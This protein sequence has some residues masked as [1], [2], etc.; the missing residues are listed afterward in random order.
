HGP[1]E[2]VL[3]RED[4]GVIEAPE[5]AVASPPPPPPPSATAPP[6]P[7]PVTVSP[8]P[9]PSRTPA[10]SAPTSYAQ[11]VLHPAARLFALREDLDRRVAAAGLG[12]LIGLVGRLQSA[13]AAVERA[14]IDAMASEVRRAIA[15]MEALRANLES[16]SALKNRLR[17]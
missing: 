7:S 8:P 3:P 14:E 4:E 9:P 5:T 15:E 11:S 2:R 10:E 17:A 12:G 1:F 13:L 6:P 16:I